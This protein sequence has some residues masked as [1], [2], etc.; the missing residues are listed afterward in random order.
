[1]AKRSP[2]S[3]PPADGL[4]RE[5]D[6]AHERERERHPASGPSLQPRPDGRPSPEVLLQLIPTPAAVH[7]GGIVQAANATAATL[8]GFSELSAMVGFNLFARLSPEELGEFTAR[9]H[10]EYAQ[11]AP[12]ANTSWAHYALT[13]RDGRLATV[14]FTCAQT[15]YRGEDAV[16]SFFIDESQDVALDGALRYSQDVAIILTDS[17]GKV[18]WVNPASQALSGYSAAELVGRSPGEVLQCDQ[19]DAAEIARVRRHLRAGSAVVTELLNRHKNGRL[20]WVRLQLLPSRSPDGK[21]LGFVGLQTDVTDEVN[22][23]LAQ[24]ESQ[25]RVL[26]TFSHEVRAPLNVIINLLDLLKDVPQQA[27]HVQ[28]MQH[29]I[30]ASH[31]LRDMVNG[32]LDSSRLQHLE[33]QQSP[34][35]ARLQDVFSQ[36]AVVAAGYPHSPR[37]E[38]RVDCPQNLPALLLRPDLLLRVLIN[39]TSNALKYTHAGRVEV[40]AEVEPCEPGAAH[41]SL[42]ISVSDTGIGI[43][44]Q[45]LQRV[46]RPFETVAPAGAN[47]SI[48]STGLGL[49]LCEQMLTTMGTTLRAYSTVGL[50]SCFS[51]EITAK[52]A[53][54]MAPR[55]ATEGDA[56]AALSSDGAAAPQ[57]QTS[58]LPL[59]GMRLMVVDDDPVSLL[60]AQ[61]QLQRSG[62][63]V[64]AMA[65]STAVVHTLQSLGAGHIDAVLTD[66][67]MPHLDGIGLARAIRAQAGFEH[68]RVIGLSGETDALKVQQAAA[69]GITERI[70]KPFDMAK[71]VALLKQQ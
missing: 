47:G 7:I 24:R 10:S 21:L 18:A 49:A 19:T 39:L 46:L 4:H 42:R 68:Q 5:T 48:E 38:L 59:A 55:V 35:P 23:R 1:M 40:R 34:Q 64:W 50:G 26:A 3:P 33:Q 25:S 69:A 70:E 66:I 30:A 32:V 44:A 36:L 8:F 45:D 54:W 9:R 57:T 65:D 71:L 16:L 20:Y 12:G 13:R 67:Q 11:C 31:T 61:A 27:Q 6:A 51:F 53:P 17:R 14:A 29:A 41:R 15:Q 37:V 63:Q 62:A 43:D 60:V 56:P 22:R 28:W 58:P 2:G 52:V